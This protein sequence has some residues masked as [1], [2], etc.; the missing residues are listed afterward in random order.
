MS[1]SKWFVLV[2]LVGAVGIGSACTQQATDEAK[3][4]ADAALDAT[5]EG[6]DKTL[7]AVKEGAGDI[8]QQ[9]AEKAKEVAST[10]GEAIT[11]G[12]ITTKVSAR[13]V[14]E[15]LLKGSKIDVDTDN[16]EVTLK[17]TVTSEAAKSRAATIARDTEGVTR[18]VN[19]LV[20]T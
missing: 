1:I 9:A 5:K 8:A 15:E 2:A 16:R 20:V 14:D 3:E 12:W 19:Q 13:F 18:V 17:G 11:D 4:D 7:D 10:T 6:V